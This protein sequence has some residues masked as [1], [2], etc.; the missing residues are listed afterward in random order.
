MELCYVPY[1]HFN[2]SAWAKL[3]TTYVLI[4]LDSIEIF[5]LEFQKFALEKKKNC[6]FPNR[7]LEL[8]MFWTI[9]W[10]LKNREITRSYMKKKKSNV[11]SGKIQLIYDTIKLKVVK[12]FGNKECST[13][14]CWIIIRTDIFKRVSPSCG[15]FKK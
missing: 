6:E 8:L 3:G 14:G 11:T 4:F 13:R 15:R 10:F 2:N 1:W 5:F 12:N 7:K 9:A